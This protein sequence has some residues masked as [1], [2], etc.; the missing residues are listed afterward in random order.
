M[1][2][3]GVAKQTVNFTIF[4]N[5]VLESEMTPY[6]FV[7][8]LLT[9]LSTDQEIKE[10]EKALDTQLQNV[11]THIK[12][13][14]EPLA[15]KKSPDYR[16]S[17]KESISVVEAICTEIVGEKTTLGNALGRLSKKGIDL[18]DSLKGA[19]EKLYGWS[20]T[21]DGIRHSLSEQ[22]KVDHEDA[23]WA[24]VS[25]SAFVNYLVVKAD[26]AGIKF[27]SQK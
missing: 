6:G 10:V 12:R 9:R 7:G 3:Y 23:L 20:S 2:N 1:P 21:K 18:P 19:F 25:C 5:K 11:K 24:L 22:S 27:N 4:C 26:K 16:N 13:A 15:D 14:H 17:L 8:H